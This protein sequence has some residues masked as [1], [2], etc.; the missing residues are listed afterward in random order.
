MK[1]MKTVT[2]RRI[3]E[4]QNLDQQRGTTTIHTGIML[5][6]GAVNYFLH[7]SICAIFVTSYLLLSQVDFIKS[8]AVIKKGS[9]PWWE[10]K[11]KDVGFVMN[12]A[13][14]FFTL[15]ML[16]RRGIAR[17]KEGVASK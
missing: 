5:S 7:P 14:G 1:K 6:L 12:S 3:A 15:I 11:M 9:E 2:K 8:L 17:L 10:W 4:L 13:L 16:T